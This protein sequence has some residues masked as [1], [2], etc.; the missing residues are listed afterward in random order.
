MNEPKKG[1]A[2]P[3]LDNAIRLRWVLR[4]IHAKCLKWS[5]VSPGDLQT[6]VDM[7]YVEVVNGDL[8]ITLSG[9][10]EKELGD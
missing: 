7:R 4:D 10:N 8:V 2:A 1:L 3:G 9:R 6:L 5:P